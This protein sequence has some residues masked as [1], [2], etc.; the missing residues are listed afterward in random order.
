MCVAEKYLCVIQETHDYPCKI[1]GFHGS[2]YEELRLLGYKN[3]VCTSQET[4]YVS[5]TVSN[6]LMLCK[7]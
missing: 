5:A 3:P 1:R 2:D 7:I 6:R 4:Y